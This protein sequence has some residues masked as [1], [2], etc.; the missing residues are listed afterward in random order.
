MSLKSSLINLDIDVY[1]GA[2]SSFTLVEDDDRTEE[3][4]TKNQKRLT[5][6]HYSQ[7]SRQVKVNAAVGTFSGAPD[8]RAITLRFFGTNNITSVKVNGKSSPYNVSD[9][10]LHVELDTHSVKQTMLIELN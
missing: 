4:R 1:V 3:Y 9:G 5:Q 6:I 8:K 7:S 10:I 2:D